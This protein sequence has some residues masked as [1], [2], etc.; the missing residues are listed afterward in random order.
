MII[1][2]VAKLKIKI[3]RVS[4]DFLEFSKIF[5]INQ[6]FLKFSRICLVCL[7]LSTIFQNLSLA[8]LIMIKPFIYNEI[9]NPWPEFGA[10]G[11]SIDNTLPN[12]PSENIVVLAIQST[13]SIFWQFTSFLTKIRVKIFLLELFQIFRDYFQILFQIISGFFLDF[14]YC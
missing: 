13:F 5:R 12:T 9:S 6:D 2:R 11:F 8:T 1:I 4:K 7:G 10:G 3:S 14:V